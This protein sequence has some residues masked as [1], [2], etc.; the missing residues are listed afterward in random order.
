[1]NGGTLVLNA[2]YEVLASV[3]WQRAIT[4]VV[5]GHAEIFE[6]DSDRMIHSQSL[7]IP[8]PTIIRLTKYVLVKHRQTRELRLSKKGVLTRDNFTCAYCAGDAD[9]VDHVQPQSRKG[10]NTWENLVAAC[11]DCNCRKD[12][13][14]PEEANMPLLWQPYR[15][16]PWADVQQQV[17]G[18]LADPQPAVTI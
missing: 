7:D 8:H 1:M 12:N 9:T 6:S 3:S 14:T 5:T 17:W 13:R 2:S 16:Q 4:L 15:P 18:K 11:K 10:L